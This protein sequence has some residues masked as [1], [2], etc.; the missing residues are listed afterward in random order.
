MSFYLK[1][2][3]VLPSYQHNGI[4]SL[5][6]EAVEETIHAMLEEDWAV[7]L[8]CISTPD[9]VSFYERHGFAP[10]PNEWDGP[11]MLRMLRKTAEETK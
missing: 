9:A 4:G 2:F 6:M 11:G 1:D 7:S 8:E 3:A 5:L 10:R